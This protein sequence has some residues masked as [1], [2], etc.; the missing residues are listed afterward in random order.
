MVRASA[1][2]GALKLG[3]AE[4]SPGAGAKDTQIADEWVA[5]CSSTGALNRFSI[6]AGVKVGRNLRFA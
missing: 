4:G 5:E 1:E 6:P 2:I 3:G